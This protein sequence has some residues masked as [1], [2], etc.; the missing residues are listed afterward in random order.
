MAALITATLAIGVNS[1]MAEPSFCPLV[2]DYR[3][4][5]T[6][7][8]STQFDRAQIPYYV[9][10]RQSH[11]ILVQQ[12]HVTRAANLLTRLSIEVSYQQAQN[13]RAVAN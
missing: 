6:G 7:F 3:T 12:E 5:D 10:F 2:E 1:V 8:I 9:D 4:L 13:C 11:Q